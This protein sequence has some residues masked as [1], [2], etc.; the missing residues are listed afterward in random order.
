MLD[1]A[2]HDLLD[3]HAFVTTF[4]RPLGEPWP[5]LSLDRLL[6]RTPPDLDP[7]TAKKAVRDLLRVGG[8]KPAGRN[9][10]AAE[11]V[12]KAIPLGK[13][14][15]INAAVDACNAASYRSGLPISVV[16][17][18]LAVEPL[19]VAIAEAGA[20]YVF[21]PSGQEIDI[22]GLWCLHDAQGPCAN[23]VKDSQRTKTHAA[24]VRTLSI[25]WGTTALEGRAEAAAA[26]Y[27][28]A[29]ESAGARTESVS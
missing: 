14:G 4:P 25:V 17:L 24:T 13:L 3:A 28:A 5:E 7:E 23:A 18:D 2:D 16:D 29:L 22:G 9:K 21:N 15:A 10:P 20:R 12:Q 6:E 27:R 26:W 1:V 8:F 19:R 11:Y